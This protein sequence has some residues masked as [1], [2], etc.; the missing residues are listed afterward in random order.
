MTQ[1]Y[2]HRG[3]KGEAPEN[4]LTSFQQCLKHGVRHCELDLHLSADNEL[5]VIHDT[6]LKRT[7]GRRGKVAEHASADLATYD[8]RKG[9]RAGYHPARFRGLKS[10]SKSATSITGNWRSKA[11]HAPGQ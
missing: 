6:T 1:I 8:A 9:A 7:T 10:C 2:G 5:M 11:P 3:A 4:T